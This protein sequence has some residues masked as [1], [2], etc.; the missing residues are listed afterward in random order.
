VYQA[1]KNITT[2]ERLNAR[3]YDYL[4]DG[5]GKFCNPFDQGVVTNL[6]EFFHLKEPLSALPDDTRNSSVNIV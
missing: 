6:K 1:A 2:N 4:K 5:N 3:R